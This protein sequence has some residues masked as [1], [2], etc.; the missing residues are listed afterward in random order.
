MTIQSKIYFPPPINHSKW[1][2]KNKHMALNYL[3]RIIKQSFQIREVS[4][5]H[6][7]G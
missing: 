1:D 7:V 3:S 5:T 4:L 2:F 6:A